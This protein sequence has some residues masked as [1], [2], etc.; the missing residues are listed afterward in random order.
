M[1]RPACLRV[2]L[3]L[4]ASAVFVA[5]LSA[6][7]AAGAP[8]GEKKWFRG[9]AAWV[10]EMIAVDDR[11][12]AVYNDEA[13]TFDQLADALGDYSTCRARLVSKAGG[14][15]SRRSRAADFQFQ[16]AC[17]SFA[18]FVRYFAQGF[19]YNTWEEAEPHFAASF[20]FYDDA[21]R[22]MRIGVAKAPG[23]SYLCQIKDF[24]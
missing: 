21:W 8:P 18:E 20:R 7:P 16:K 1:R 11:F 9:A 5:V 10:K 4:A 14:P 3:A 12:V 6:S 23:L 19:T 15:V 24:C 22:Y 2:L 13:A 17:K